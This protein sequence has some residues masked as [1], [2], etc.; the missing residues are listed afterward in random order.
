MREHQCRI[1]TRRHS[2]CLKVPTSSTR[3]LR[4]PLGGHEAAQ[5]PSVPHLRTWTGPPRLASESNTPTPS[6]N[7]PQWRPPSRPQ[8]SKHTLPKLSSKLHRHPNSNNRS[9]GVHINQSHQTQPASQPPNAN[10]MTKRL[11]QQASLVLPVA[12]SD[13]APL[14]EPQTRFP[15]TTVSSSISRRLSPCPGKTSQPASKATRTRPGM[16]PPCR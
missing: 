14:P 10:A 2:R 3:Q 8:L 15:T 7:Q 5:A 1:S 13:D 6:P 11:P 9:P 12:T 16:S 4:T